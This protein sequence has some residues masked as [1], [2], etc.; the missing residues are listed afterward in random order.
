MDCLQPSGTLLEQL[1]ASTFQEA[2]DGLL[3]N[4]ILKVDIYPT[5]GELLP[6]VVAC[7]LEG[8]VVEASVVAVVVQ[9]FDSVFCRVLFEGKLGSKCFVGL[10]I[11]LELENWIW[12]KWLTKTVAHV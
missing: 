9:D 2:L 1:L 8:V 4:S 10:V 5:K 11:K 6:C 3:D 12:P 7:L